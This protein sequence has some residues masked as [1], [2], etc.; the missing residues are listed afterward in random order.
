MIFQTAFSIVTGH[1]GHVC[2]IWDQSGIRIIG[3]MQ[4][5]VC[6][7]P[8]FFFLKHY[9]LAWLHC[10]FGAK[11]RG[12]FCS[13]LWNSDSLGEVMIKIFSEI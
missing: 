9:S 4:V 3:I 1:N 6:L 10:F 8:L 2:F 11:I 5:G 12:K 7:C 13:F